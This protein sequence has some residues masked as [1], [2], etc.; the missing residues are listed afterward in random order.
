MKKPHEKLTDEIR[1]LVVQR[2]ACFQTPSNIAA[3]LK[4]DFAVEITPQAI[5]AYDPTKVAGAKLSPKWR[6][7]F[8]AARKRFIE[9]VADIPIANMAVRLATLDR[10]A[11]QAEARG[12]LVLAMQATEQAAKEMGGIYTNRSRVE[13]TGKDGQ[14]IE[15][16]TRDYSK[17]VERYRA[18]RSS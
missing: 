12:N 6:A 2:L 13:H 10:I 11:T 8:E 17:M 14:P 16:I 3:T 9:N 4:K 1:A 7:A 5:Q 15:T 18:G